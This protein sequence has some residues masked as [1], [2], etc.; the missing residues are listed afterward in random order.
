V[1][2]DTGHPGRDVEHHVADRHGTESICF[3]L[4][5]RPGPERHRARSLPRPRAPI[6]TTRP[7]PAAGTCLNHHLD[8]PDP[9]PR[10]LTQHENHPSS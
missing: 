9:R 8:H 5:D 6:T 1:V 3:T 7:A 4:N 2:C 10:R